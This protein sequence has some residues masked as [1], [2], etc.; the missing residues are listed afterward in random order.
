MPPPARGDK[1]LSLSPHALLHIVG[2]SMLTFM[3]CSMDLEG[4]ELEWK[5]VLGSAGRAQRLWQGKH[6]VMSQLSLVH[7]TPGTC[8]T[9][10]ASP[11]LVSFSM[12]IWRDPGLG[13]FGWPW[14]LTGP[15][16]LMAGE[17]VQEGHSQPWPNKIFPYLVA[18]SCWLSPEV[19][20]FR[21]T[22]A[23]PSGNCG[24]GRAST[25]S[26]QSSPQSQHTPGLGRGWAG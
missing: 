3:N 23:V 21:T 17:V 1:A 12:G 16:Q 6:R 2:M 5:R 24:E 11:L 13:F 8:D 10:A 18:T 20:S 4:S 14:A 26:P 9:F 25:A 15:G 7:P 22:R 19:T